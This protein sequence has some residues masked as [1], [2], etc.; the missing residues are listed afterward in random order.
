ML[1][2]RPSYVY[3]C[4]CA[5]RVNSL[6]SPIDRDDN[7]SYCTN[8]QYIDYYCCTSKQL[9]CQMKSTTRSMAPSTVL[10]LVVILVAVRVHGQFDP[11]GTKLLL[12]R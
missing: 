5:A 11:Q 10:V 8:L 1:S 7:E 2:G 9:H 12:T 6:A 3:T 4:A